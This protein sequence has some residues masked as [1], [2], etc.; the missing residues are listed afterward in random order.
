M[1]CSTFS[2]RNSSFVGGNSPSGP[3][4]YEQEE[5]INRKIIE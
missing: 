2:L 1:S 3:A 5:N 4:I